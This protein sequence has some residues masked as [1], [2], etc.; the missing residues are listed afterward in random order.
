[1]FICLDSNYLSINLN[2]E[3]SLRVVLT[4]F[5]WKHI[6]SF[7]S[8]YVWSKVEVC[9]S[10]NLALFSLLFQLNLSWFI[11]KLFF[12]FI[13]RHHIL[14]IKRIIYF[15]CW[16]FW[17]NPSLFRLMMFIISSHDARNSRSSLE[18]IYSCTF[19]FKVNF[20]LHS[21][22]VLV[23]CCFCGDHILSNSFSSEVLL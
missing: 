11:Y 20:N 23:F 4:I 18:V 22:S 13:I 14:D 9:F 19:N 7:F 10:K 6:N 15:G 2:I 12:I 17:P 5:H 3:A 16:F 21:V 1:M 8:T